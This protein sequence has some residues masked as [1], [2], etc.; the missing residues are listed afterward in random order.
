MEK[1]GNYE[2]DTTT[3]PTKWMQSNGQQLRK[4]AAAGLLWLERH[5]Q[6]VNALN[7][8]PVPVAIER[9]PRRPLVSHSSTRI[10]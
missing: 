5:Q 3:F 4:L 2:P 10:C 9:M 6:E 8:F 7:V 1:I